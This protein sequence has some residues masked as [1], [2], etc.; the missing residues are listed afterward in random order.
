VTAEAG[1]YYADTSALVRAYLPEEGDHAELRGLLLDGDLPVV[2]SALTRVEFASAAAAAGRA[3]RLRRPRVLLD[4]FDADCRDDGPLTLLD[5]DAAAVLP[6]A[7]QLV[8][9]HPICTLD[10]IH[11]AVARTD[12]TELAAGEPVCLVTRDRQQAAV[13]ES[14]GFMVA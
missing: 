11:L 4:R 12:A 1:V 7:R 2:T 9:E 10:A 6:L 3:G 8:R 5:L 13:A 14:L